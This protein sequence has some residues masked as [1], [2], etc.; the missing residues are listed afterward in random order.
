M[1]NSLGDYAEPFSS[2]PIWKLALKEVAVYTLIAV[3][4]VAGGLFV[5]SFFETYVSLM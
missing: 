4:L 5:L 1:Y 2:T 3:G